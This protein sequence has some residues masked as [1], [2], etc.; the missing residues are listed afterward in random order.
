MRILVLVFC[1]VLLVGSIGAILLYVSILSILSVSLVLAGM[2][3]MYVL[4]TY[5]ER[6]R[7]RA[8]EI[9]S[10]GAMP[11]MQRAHTQLDIRAGA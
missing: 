2:M 6:H 9:P 4:G 3:F 8:R 7:A 11:R 10:D 5:I 1:G